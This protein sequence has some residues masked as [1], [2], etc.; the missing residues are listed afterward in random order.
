M[1]KRLNR[2]GL[3]I[4]GISVLAMCLIGSLDVLA[5]HIF[6]TPLPA[7]YEVTE[8]LLAMAIF[9]A[10]SSLQERRMNIFIETI[11]ERTSTGFQ[12]AVT[13]LSNILGLIFFGLIAWQCWLLAIE[14]VE[15]REYTQGIYA[16]PVYPTKIVFACGATLI[17]AQYLKDTLASFTVA[18]PEPVRAPTH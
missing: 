6:G 9:L 3:F 15:I 4:A 10:I 14:S 17:V 11:Y 13:R 18:A 2:V 5:S 16:I 8:L 12:R 1:I 7:A